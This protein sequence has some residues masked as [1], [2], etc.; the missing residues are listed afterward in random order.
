MDKNN[1]TA[2]AE[3][4][5][6]EITTKPIKVK[7]PVIPSPREEASGRKPIR[8]K[9]HVGKEYVRK[10]AF[11]HIDGRKAPTEVYHMYPLLS[12]WIGRTAPDGVNPR[13]HD[14]ECLKSP[15]ARQIEQTIINNPE[16]FYL[17][18]RGST[19]IADK[20]EFDAQSGNVEIII[21][22]PENQGL[23]DGATTDAVIAKVQTQLAREILEKKDATYN[24]L[25]EGIKSGTKK[26]NHK[27]PEVLRNGRVHLEVI[28]GLDDRTRMANLVQGR[29]TSRQV[30]G[31]SMADFKGEFDWLKSILEAKDSKFAGRIGYEENSASDILVLD[32]LS[33]L[34]LFHPEFDQKEED[35][36]EKAPV[37]AY[38]N[39]GRMDAR[40]AD[41]ELRKGYKKLKPIII[42][43]LRL[44]DYVYANFEAAYDKVFGPKAR[45]GRREGVKSLLMGEAYAL[46]LT[47]LKTNYIIPNGFIF[48]LLASFRAL[49]VHKPDGAAW[50]VDPFAFFDKYGK[51][52]VAELIEQVDAQGGN[53]NVAG[54]RKLVYTAIHAKARLC[55]NDEL[56]SRRNKK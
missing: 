11:P 10:M 29:N 56:D 52:L 35:S 1:T 27:L 53:P 31:W 8:I 9:L 43:I 32:V 7:I 55:L 2:V 14:P 36:V 3:V 48:P 20:V 30:R 23:A 37:I 17:A 24:D 25:I 41:D 13:S 45:L 15:V 42:D 39:K 21:I 49:V 5:E 46:P 50:R 54:K 51:K 4:P 38:A 26:D 47:G 19:L 28:V 18:N 6:T 40:L 22:D 16:D 44:H 34:T 12:E 33:I